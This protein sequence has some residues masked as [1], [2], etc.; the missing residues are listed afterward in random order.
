MTAGYQAWASSAASQQVMRANRSRDTGPELAVR[1][2]LHAAGLRYRVDC[3]P[4]ASLR[5]RADVVFR[6][7]RVAVF[8]D[9]CYWHACPEHGTVARTNAEYWSAKLARNVERDQETTAL[10]QSAGWRVLRY[11]E[12][13][14][15]RAVAASIFAALAER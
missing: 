2:L 1:R 5:R 4:E 14:D 10:L 13:D 8:I 9:G 3:R 12:H 6:S 11:W 7:R 15:P